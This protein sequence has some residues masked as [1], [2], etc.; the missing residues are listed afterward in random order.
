MSTYPT[1]MAKPAQIRSALRFYRVMAVIA[2]I[3]LFVLLAAM[4]VKYGPPQ[5]PGFSA[6]WSPIHGVIYLVY[7]VSIA[8]LGF[9]SAWGLKRIVLNLL[10]GF[11]P[12]LPFVAEARVTRST[13]A[14]LSRVYF[15]GDDQPAG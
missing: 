13:E 15:A 11:V 2:G 8:N 14:L 4:F 6:I 12:I 1:T 5:N 3:A 7:A 10:T 9:K